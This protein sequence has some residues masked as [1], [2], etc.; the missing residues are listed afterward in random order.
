MK[1]AEVK[2]FFKSKGIRPLKRFGQNFLLR[3]DLARQMIDRLNPDPGEKIIEIGPGLGVLTDELVKR[4]H[5]VIAI[6][7]DRSLAEFL[8]E[9]YKEAAARCQ[10]KCMDFLDYGFE[11]VAQGEK[12]SVIGNLPYYISTPILFQIIKYREKITRAIFTLQREMADRLA[13]HEG[14]K[15]YGRLTVAVSVFASVKKVFKISRGSFY[16]AP[17]VDSATVLLELRSHPMLPESFDEAIY[18]RVIKAAFSSRRKLLSNALGQGEG[19]FSES[20]I[21]QALDTASIDG[22]RRAERLSVEEFI[23]LSAAFCGLLEK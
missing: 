1:A 20:Q 9:T 13:A 11:D 16:P 15:D 4:G 18:S 19:G 14:S 6:E 3:D 23:A 10:I 8:K 7:K 2:Q 17:K 12:C 22:S 21:K 5:A